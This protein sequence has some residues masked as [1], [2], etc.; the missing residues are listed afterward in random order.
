M[1]G[2]CLVAIIA[3]MLVLF[4]AVHV[5]NAESTRNDPPAAYQLAG[6]SWDIWDGW[7]C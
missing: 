2:G 3:V 1:K 6:G 5:V 7:R 4:A